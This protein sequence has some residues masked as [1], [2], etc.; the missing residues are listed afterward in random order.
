MLSGPVIL[1]REPDFI[2]IRK[3]LRASFFYHG[4][5]SRLRA[6]HC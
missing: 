4:A 6:V 2:Q 5:G 1:V 3:K